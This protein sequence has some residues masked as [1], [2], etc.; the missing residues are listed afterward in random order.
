[1]IKLSTHSFNMRK[2]AHTFLEKRL[3]ELST[4][5]TYS[6][7][8][9]AL[10]TVSS[11]QKAKL[12]FWERT[13]GLQSNEASPAFKNRWLMA[14]PAFATHMCIGS[15]WAWSIMADTITKEV[16]FVAPCAADW[17]LMESAFPLSIVFLLMG[18]SASAVGRWQ[19][20]VGART[21]MAASA[22]AFGGGIAVGAAGIHFHSLPLLYTGYGFMAGTG[23]GLAY[24]PP[25]QTLMQWFPDKKGIASGL[26]IAGFG[27]GALVFTPAAQYLMHKFAKM[28]EFLGPAEQFV[29][30]FQDGKMFADVNGQMVEVVKA[31]AADLA[32]LPYDLSEGLY[33]VG[34]GSTGAAEALAIMGGAYFVTI[35]ASA[36]AL[37]SPHPSYAPPPTNPAAATSTS[38]IT[39]TSKPSSTSTTT[40]VISPTPLPP[41]APPT[42]P[43]VVDVSLEA[44]MRAP[45]FYQL[46]TTFFCLACGGMGMFSVA[47]PMMAEVFSSAL[48]GVVTSAFAANFLLLLSSGNLGGRLGWA[49]ISDA[50]GRRNMFHAFTI[51]SIPLYLLLP[52][53]VDSVVTT[54]ST[55]PLYG[56]CITT[57][58]AISVMGGLFAIIP[59][60]QA[61]LFGTKFVGAIHGRM[62][63]FSSAA[64]IAGPSMLINL[65]A[66]SEK[67]AITELLTKVSPE[68]F[69]QTFGAPMEQASELL[70]AK[71]LTISKL[72]VLAPPGTIDPTPHLYDTTMYTLSGFMA[73]AVLAHGMV[74]PVTQPVLASAAAE[75]ATSSLTAS[76]TSSTGTLID[77]DAVVEVAAESTILTAAAEGQNQVPAEVAVEIEV[78]GDREVKPVAGVPVL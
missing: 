38:S 66:M 34:S 22:V 76:T 8:S 46:G 13:L 43:A 68:K 58:L 53:M 37:R 55:L 16:G 49:A 32:K 20:K 4:K 12:S 26:T 42:A 36:F 78:A 41:I 9:R 56:F 45:Q 25:V 15:P 10:S 77:V 28:P 75:A 61:D 72:L 63:L 65:R 64:A 30:K 33:I 27:S 67:A 7:H 18:V 59:A 71:S 11:E 62:L 3:R 1:M 31:G 24:T 17:S 54:G 57:T 47:K 21:A 44:A 60:Y 14:V 52:S 23:I 74:K 39:S 35:L 51:G 69:Q 19:M 50:L 40:A 48:P 6:V 29:T 73:M 5:N 2:G 70:A